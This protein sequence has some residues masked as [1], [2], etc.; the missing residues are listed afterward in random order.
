MNMGSLE[1]VLKG[2]GNTQR[3]LSICSLNLQSLYPVGH[4]VL[5]PLLNRVKMMVLCQRGDCGSGDRIRY[6]W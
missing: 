5:Q 3:K 6:I 1:M 2:V 4:I